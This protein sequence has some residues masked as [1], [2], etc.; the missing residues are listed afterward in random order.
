[1]KFC[2][3]SFISHRVKPL[4]G[5]GGTDGA[6]EL[7]V[8]PRVMVTPTV[9]SDPTSQLRGL[10]CF[11]DSFHA[12]DCSESRLRVETCDAILCNADDISRQFCAI[13]VLVQ[14]CPVL[15]GCI[16][17]ILLETRQW[18]HSVQGYTQPL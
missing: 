13:Q 3:T 14:D 4:A 1:M 11:L 17:D 9:C 2:C 10:A 18:S 5:I 12:W 7:R 15:R 8:L 16:R 6:E